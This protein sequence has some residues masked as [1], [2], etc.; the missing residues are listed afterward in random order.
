MATKLVMTF[1][2]NS[3]TTTK[4][5]YNH[6]DP[7]VTAVAIRALATGIISNGSIFQAVP[8]LAKSAKLVTTSEQDIELSA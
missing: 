2:T 8:T 3:G 1:A 5:S 4:F 6:T 7:E